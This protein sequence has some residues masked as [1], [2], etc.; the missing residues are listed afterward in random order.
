VL[1]LRRFAALPVGAQSLIRSFLAF[2][3]ESIEF[4]SVVLPVPGPPVIT[5][6]LLFNVCSIAIFCVTANWIL[7]FFQPKE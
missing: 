7:S 3:I 1:S 6:T 2:S 4:T 5:I